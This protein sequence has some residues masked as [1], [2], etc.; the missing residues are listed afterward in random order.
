MGNIGGYLYLNG[1]IMALDSNAAFVNTDG[2]A[3]PANKSVNATGPTAV[4][5]TEFVKLMIDNYMFGRQ[6]A[7][8]N[9]ASIIPNGS[10]EEDGD[11]QELEALK[12]GFS[13][14]GE[15]VDWY[16]NVDP[17]TLGHKILLL[18]GQGVLV[19]DFPD[20]VAA[21]YVGDGDNP[22]AVAFYRADDAAGTIRNIAGV[23][24]ILPD[25]TGFYPRYVSEEIFAVRVQNN[26][27]ATV[28]SQS[29]DFLDAGTPVQRTAAGLVNINFKAGIFTVPPA[30]TGNIDRQAL[31]FSTTTI[32]FGNI[33]ATGCRTISN[34][35]A[36]AGVDLD[37]IAV[38]QKQGADTQQFPSDFIQAGIRY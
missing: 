30:P 10:V 38:F 18:E 29:A 28:I 17:A 15:A 26:G 20:L 8:L 16:G 33:L 24:F 27:T 4:D 34:N 12:N 32:R 21:T 13:A 9:F 22:T 5:G 7:L 1:A 19:A 36:L 6:Q 2:A 11:S 25:A 31:T 14:P 35:S 3:F 23:Y 37:F